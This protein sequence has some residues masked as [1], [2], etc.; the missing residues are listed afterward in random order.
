VRVP[1]RWELITIH[2]EP[3]WYQLQTFRVFLYG[4]IVGE[5]QT[6]LKLLAYVVAVTFAS[7]SIL[8]TIILNASIDCREQD[9]E[10]LHII[11]SQD[12]NPGQ[13]SLMRCFC[14]Y[15]AWDAERGKKW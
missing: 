11:Q 3:P 1:W 12:T 5:K 6:S 4:S 2:N 15:S 9:E 10:A 7:G 13:P 14:S 8:Q